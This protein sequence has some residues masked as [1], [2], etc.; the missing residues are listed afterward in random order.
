MSSHHKSE[1]VRKRSIW[2]SYA[3]LPPK[4]RLNIS[5]ALCAVA[6]AGIVISDRLEEAMPPPPKAAPK[7]S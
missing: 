4:T 6:I 7:Q 2:E 1:A 3:V 5:L